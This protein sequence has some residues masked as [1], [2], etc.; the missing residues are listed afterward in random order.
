MLTLGEQGYPCCLDGT[1]GKATPE[2]E[3]KR[4]MQVAAGAAALLY[5][6]GS[7]SSHEES[8][9]TLGEVQLVVMAP[10][11]CRGLNGFHI[12]LVSRK[13][14]GRRLSRSFSYT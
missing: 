13:S 9:T 10:D 11:G 8:W 12:S 5:L 6:V 3:I 1:V 14:G 7:G 2:W 4:R